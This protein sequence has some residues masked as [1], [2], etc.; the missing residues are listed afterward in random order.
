[1]REPERW[2][3]ATIILLLFVATVSFSHGLLELRNLRKF[4]KVTFQEEPYFLWTYRGMDVL[5]QAFLIFAA[6]TAVAALF[7]E[8]RGPG[9]VEEPVVEGGE[10]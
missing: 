2:V 6:A 4:G 8:E 7:R 3:S 10:G 9:A 5:V 1:M